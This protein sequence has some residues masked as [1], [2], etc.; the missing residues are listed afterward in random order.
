MRGMNCSCMWLR[1][2]VAKAVPIILLLMANI[3]MIINIRAIRMR[4]MSPTIS[5]CVSRV[6]LG[7]K[8]GI[9]IWLMDDVIGVNLEDNFNSG[10]LFSRSVAFSWDE[11]LK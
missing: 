6:N 8:W 4:L 2:M 5:M 1:A 11:K 3:A 9:T 7:S 10:K